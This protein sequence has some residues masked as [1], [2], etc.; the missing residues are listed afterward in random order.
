MEFDASSAGVLPGGLVNQTEI[1]ILICYILYTVK[2]PVPALDLCNLLV[3]KG[4]A[5]NFEVSD[6]IKSLYRNENLV[7]V[8]EKEDTYTVT[9]KGANIAQML[10]SS[11]PASVREKACKATLKM[12]S[13]IRNAKETT[14]TVDKE[15]NNM[16]IT[17]S[18]L[19]GDCPVMSVKLLVADD[20]QAASIKKKFLDDPA[21][22][23]SK[24]IDLFTV[25]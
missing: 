1:R 7:C 5:N 16:F 22:I 9:E 3:Y 8:D 15:G 6:A 14:I 17:C 18:A 21:A 13:D 24:I 2:Q 12:L 20:V 4:I 11:V 23:Y 19:D 10:K 25:E